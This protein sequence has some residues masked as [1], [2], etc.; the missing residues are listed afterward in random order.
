MGDIYISGGVDGSSSTNNP[1]DPESCTGV[2]PNP[3]RCPPPYNTAEFKPGYSKDRPMGDQKFQLNA[4]TGKIE[5]LPSMLGIYNFSI[6]V[7]EFIAG[8]EISS[9]NLDWSFLVSFPKDVYASGFTFI[10]NNENG[11][12][13]EH[14]DVK[15]SVPL[16]FSENDCG[17]SFK[18]NGEYIFFPSGPK[19]YNYESADSNYI[20]LDDKIFDF[21][22]NIN[23]DKNIPVARKQNKLQGVDFTFSFERQDRN[24]LGVLYIKLQNNSK[25]YKKTNLTINTDAEKL[26]NNMILDNLV[27]LQGSNTIQYSTILSPGREEIKLIYFNEIPGEKFETKNEYTIEVIDSFT[28]KSTI[29]S[30]NINEFINKINYTETV[31]VSPNKNDKGGFDKGENLTYIVDYKMALPYVEN[32]MTIELPEKIDPFSYY[33]INDNVNINYVFISKNKI[34]IYYTPASQH[35]FIKFSLNPDFD[36]LI[37]GE[38]LNVKISSKD[39][40]GFLEEVKSIYSKELDTIDPVANSQIKII[41]N[42]TSENL[43]LDLKLKEGEKAESIKLID[44]AGK[45]AAYNFSPTIS[46][47]NLSKG[48]YIVQVTTNQ[49]IIQGGRFYKI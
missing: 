22:N 3:E 24:S 33:L 8:E 36:K 37:I 35:A 47:S 5:V 7:K 25:S 30:K 19:I 38:E 12:F 20:I 45:V 29:I 11:T 48:I 10:D 44:H 6:D 26:N 34:K 18:E 43:S 16:K 49:G 23:I 13:E 46:I 14:A 42:I 21:I 17:V 41:P 31:F 40:T 4:S 9:T 39:G 28:Q 1:G 15:V 2:R 27:T 32:L